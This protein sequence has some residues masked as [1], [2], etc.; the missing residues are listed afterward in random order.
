MEEVGNAYILCWETSR[1]RSLGRL[2]L[3]WNDNI[4]IELK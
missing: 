4:K 2:G 1:K 3:T